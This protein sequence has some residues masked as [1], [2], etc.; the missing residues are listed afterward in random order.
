MSTTEQRKTVM[1]Q[2]VRLAR[3]VAENDLEQPVLDM[4]AAGL[5]S[6]IAVAEGDTSPARIESDLATELAEMFAATGADR[7]GWLRR[8]Q[9]GVARR[10][11][12]T[13]DLRAQLELLDKLQ[14][15]NIGTPATTDTPVPTLSA[16]LPGDSYAGPTR[17]PPTGSEAADGDSAAFDGGVEVVE[18][19]LVEAV[20]PGPEMIEQTTPSQTR[21]R[22]PDGHS[23]AAGRSAGYMGSLGRPR[24]GCIEISSSS[25]H[26]TDQRGI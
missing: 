20:E 18:A 6:A 3:I 25:D 24:S 4:V 9:A 12:E 7:P 17:V 23:Y 19:E 2:A 5:A 13:L 14:W 22:V 26:L 11:L 1:Q 8:M 16:P 21:Y 10:H 15:S